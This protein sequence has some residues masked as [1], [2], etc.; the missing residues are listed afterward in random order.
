MTAKIRQ[1]FQSTEHQKAFRDALVQVV[2]AGC[3]W[4]MSQRLLFAT[5]DQ[6]K[7]AAIRAT[8]NIEKAKLN[9]P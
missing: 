2:G 7:T 3:S 6:L 5:E 4:Y 1:Q 9:K 8:E